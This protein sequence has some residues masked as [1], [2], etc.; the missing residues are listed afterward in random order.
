MCVCE[1]H[2]KII[3]YKTHT[4]TQQR[5][6]KEAK[7]TATDGSLGYGNGWVFR[8]SCFVFHYRTFFCVLT[9]VFVF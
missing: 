9:G 6:E 5:G 4:N 2:T 3:L 7:L 8:I 1:R